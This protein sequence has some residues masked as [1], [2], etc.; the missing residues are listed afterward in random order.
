[1]DEQTRLYFEK[2]LAEIEHRLYESTIKPEQLE[3]TLQLMQKYGL[4]S[5]NIGSLRLEMR[6][7]PASLVG[8]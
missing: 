3:A 4:Q 5:L 7:Q 1:M 6:Y 2:R 8:Q